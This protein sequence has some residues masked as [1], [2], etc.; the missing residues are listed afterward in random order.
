MLASAGETVFTVVLAAVIV[1]GWVVLAA[2]YLL[3]F[4][5]RGS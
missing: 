5:G 2:I 3:F 1:I 4:R